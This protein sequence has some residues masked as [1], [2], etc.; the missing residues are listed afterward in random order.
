MP[1]SLPDD[2]RPLDLCSQDNL[3]DLLLDK[4]YFDGVG[5]DRLS[6]DTILI[7][8]SGA[9]LRCCLLGL[10]G[11]VAAQKPTS[12]YDELAALYDMLSGIKAE[13]LSS[14]CEN[15][16]DFLNACTK[17]AEVT[18]SKTY[19]NREED[20]L[21]LSFLAYLRGI[22]PTVNSELYLYVRLTY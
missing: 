6:Q 14:V 2:V 21:S 16:S 13:L 9:E 11:D 18:E 7:C 15:A 5:R 8:V 3:V 22:L 1:S 4:L 20:M 10:L 12:V 17:H 19:A